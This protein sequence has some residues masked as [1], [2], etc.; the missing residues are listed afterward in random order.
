[1]TNKTKPKKILFWRNYKNV[2]HIKVPSKYQ[3]PHCFQIKTR[4]SFD[5]GESECTIEFSIYKIIPI[6]LHKKNY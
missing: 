3:N 5:R 6:D 4:A 2:K 1:M